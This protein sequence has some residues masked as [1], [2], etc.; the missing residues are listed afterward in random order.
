MK[1]AVAIVAYGITFALAPRYE[2]RAQ[3]RQT[4]AV[5]AEYQSY[6]A[7]VAAANASLRLNEAGEAKRWLAAAPEKYRHW[8]WRYLQARSD[9]SITKIDLDAAPDE[10]HFSPDGSMLI[11]AF[12]DNSIRIFDA[13][14]LRE[15]KRLSGHTNAVYAAKIS[16]R[17]RA[18]AI[19]PFACG[20]WRQARSLGRAK[21]A[22]MAWPTSTSAPTANGLPFPHGI[23]KNAAWWVWFRFGRLPPAKK[24]GARISATSLS[25]I[26]VLVRTASASPRA[27]GAGA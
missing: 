10:A 14:S 18:L 12:P 11:A 26:F 1:Y 9:N 13:V 25:S 5:E 17:F 7:H 27:R 8:E 2:A 23:A 6:L 15:I 19:P 3:N 20:I 21:A 22:G 16:P 24:S 4:P